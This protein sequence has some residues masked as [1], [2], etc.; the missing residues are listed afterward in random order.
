MK[1]LLTLVAFTMG[2]CQPAMAEVPNQKFQDNVIM[3][4][5]TLKYT[6]PKPKDIDEI[7]A[8]VD[9]CYLLAQKIQKNK[10]TKE[11]FHVYFQGLK[12]GTSNN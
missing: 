3:C 8:Q 9:K 1:K 10:D 4:M 6:A 12:N 7:F 5:Y 11:P 2:A